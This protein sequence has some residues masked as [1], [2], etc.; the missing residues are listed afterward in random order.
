MKIV[1]LL[2]VSMLL[3]GCKTLDS[4]SV[5]NISADFRNSVQE[6]IEQTEEIK[7]ATELIARQLG[8]ID[9]QAENI[10]N[11]IALMPEDQINNGMVSI[12]DSAETIK[13]TVDEAQKEH[14]RI[15]ESLEDLESANH[16]ASSLLTQ[17]KKLEQLLEEY[18]ES[19]REVRREALENLHSYITLFFVI[20]FATVLIGAF[21]T[22]W[23][24]G[25][26]GGVVLGVGVLTV[27]FAAASQYYLQEIAVVGLIVLIL[28]FV[29][30]LGVIIWLL[31][32]GKNDK[33]AMKEIVS[34]VEAMKHHLTEE[35]RKQIFGPTGLASRMTSDLT[36]KVVSQIKIKNGLNKP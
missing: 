30:T 19:D 7:N 6:Q 36:K 25:K 13:E 31:L 5:E 24:N 2:F 35:E 28:G 10:L 12:E 29:V 21:L 3:L 16:R 34:L 26:L 23:V 4:P 27:G 22:F 18:K 11:E 8:D 1:S 15:D 17:T 20:G 33:V 14:I 32:D 9:L